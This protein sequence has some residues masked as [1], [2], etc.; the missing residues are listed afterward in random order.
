MTRR[1][2]RRKRE[3]ER[4]RLAPRLRA[5]RR[6]KRSRHQRPEEEAEEAVSI[7]SSLSPVASSLVAAAARAKHKERIEHECR[8]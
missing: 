5:E 7:P 3:T 2:M 4:R 8:T 6:L 1:K